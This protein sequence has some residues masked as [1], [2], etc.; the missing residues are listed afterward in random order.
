MNYKMSYA[1][2]GIILVIG[3]LFLSGC[4]GIAEPNV[5]AVNITYGQLKQMG[6]QIECT[7]TRGN[8]NIYVVL[9]KSF[10]YAKKGDNEI[11]YTYKSGYIKGD[12]E[13]IPKSMRNKNCEWYK[14]SKDYTWTGPADND[15][16]KTYLD[17]IS[18]IR[19]I[20]Y[21]NLNCKYSRM[22]VIKQPTTGICM[23]N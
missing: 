11:I 3:V 2:Y 16:V 21:S 1:T 17:K 5:N 20:S 6:G 23:L 22:D 10:I 12:S 13:L 7:Y 8:Q 14:L 18:G 19:N 15:T 9:D 4:L